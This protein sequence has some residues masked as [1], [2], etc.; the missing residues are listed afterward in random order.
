MRKIFR[1]FLTLLFMAIQF[2]FKN[3]YYLIIIYKFFSFKFKI[4][5][6]VLFDIIIYSNN[7]TIKEKNVGFF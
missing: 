7:K 2:K 5:F 3:I 1:K 6:Q 4:R